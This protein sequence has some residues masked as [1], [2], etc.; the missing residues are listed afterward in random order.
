MAGTGFTSIA[1]TY[2]PVSSLSFSVDE[3]YLGL[4]PLG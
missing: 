3:W 4:R 2:R 1:L